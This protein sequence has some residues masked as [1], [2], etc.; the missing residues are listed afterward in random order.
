M[1]LV[2]DFHTNSVCVSNS[3][4]QQPRIIWQTL[5]VKV[6]ASL[7]NLA[8]KVLLDKPLLNVE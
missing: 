3:T 5:A 2:L 6:W 4:L 1:C 8:A 7:L